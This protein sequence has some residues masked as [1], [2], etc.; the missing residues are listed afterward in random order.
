LLRSRR[1]NETGADRADAANNN[2]LPLNSRSRRF[3]PSSFC[4]IP[5]SGFP[6]AWFLLMTRLLQL[7]SGDVSKAGMA[8]RRLGILVG[9]PKIISDS[10]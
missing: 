1:G 7:I 6:R 5:L 4:V 2:E 3:N 9:P 8:C 10:P